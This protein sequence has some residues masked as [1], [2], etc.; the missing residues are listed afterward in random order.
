MDGDKLALPILDYEYDGVSEC[1]DEY[2]TAR[3]A[4]SESFSPRLPQG[5]NLGATIILAA[6]TFLPPN[7]KRSIRCSYIRNIGALSLA[8]IKRQK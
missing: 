5:L 6:T 2:G 1:K 8:V 3:P 4:F 7:L